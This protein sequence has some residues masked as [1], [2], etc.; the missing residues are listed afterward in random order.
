ME[1]MVFWH[2]VVMKDLSFFFSLFSAIWSN[3][4]KLIANVKNMRWDIMTG[5][6]ELSQFYQFY[7][8]LGI[9]LVLHQ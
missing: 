3:E 8:R 7:Y 6:N 1:I 4:I 5:P 9:S 2:T